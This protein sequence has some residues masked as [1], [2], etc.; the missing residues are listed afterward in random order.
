M[1]RPTA[2]AGFTLIELLVAMTVL[3][4]VSVG[5]ATGLGLLGRAW[6]RQEQRVAEQAAVVDG[7]ALLREQLGRAL[8]VDWGAGRDYAPP[9]LGTPD[10]VRFLNVPPDYHPGGGLALWEFALEDRRDSRALLV[11]RSAWTRDGQGMELL[12]TS[13]PR[14]LASLPADSRFGFFGLEEEARAAD[15][16]EA[17][18]GQPRLPMAVRLEGEGIETLVPLQIDLPAGCANP[19]GEQAG[20][21]EE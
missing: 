21:C 18:S 20:G 16:H 19:R 14:L 15:W 11:R 2:V 13:P 7:V 5:A 9:F 8:P 10:H 6:G 1:S 17:W 3:G 12:D 4:L